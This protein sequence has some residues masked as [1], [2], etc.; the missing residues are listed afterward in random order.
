MAESS[1]GAGLDPERQRLGELLGFDV[2][3]D[4]VDPSA[5]ARAVKTRVADLQRDI[6]V[7]IGERYGDVS[8]TL[9][10]ALQLHKSIAQAHCLVQ[11]AVVES[12]DPD[13]VLFSEE[14]ER[15]NKQLVGEIQASALEIAVLRSLASLHESFIAFDKALCDGNVQRAANL[16]IEVEHNFHFV[17]MATSSSKEWESAIPTDSKTFILIREQYLKKRDALENR[18]REMFDGAIS[19]TQKDGAWNLVVDVTGGNSE[20]LPAVVSVFHML[21]MLPDALVSFS[22]DVLSF[23]FQPFLSEKNASIEVVKTGEEAKISII[24]ETTGSDTYLKPNELF[25]RALSVI[26]FLDDVVFGKLEGTQEDATSAVSS[27]LWGHDM[28]GLCALLIERLDAALPSE[29][30]TETKTIEDM[31]VATKAFEESLRHMRWLTPSTDSALAQYVSNLGTRVAKKRQQHVLASARSI[32]LADYHNSVVVDD[33]MDP[34][35]SICVDSRKDGE[36]LPGLTYDKREEFGGAAFSIERMAVTSCTQRIVALVHTTLRDL[37]HGS[38]EFNRIIWCAVRDV[39]LMF[40]AVVPFIHRNHIATMSRLAMLHYNDCNYICHHLMAFGVMYAHLLPP[41]L[42]ENTRMLDLVPTFRDMGVAT[43]V[44]QLQYQHAE[45]EMLLDRED[46]GGVDPQLLTRR[47][48]M[49]LTRTFNVWAEVLGVVTFEQA[50]GLMVA[51]IPPRIFS[52]VLG[53]IESDKAKIL[54]RCRGACG[55]E[56]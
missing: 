44:K 12:K 40:Q 32:I 20:A 25:A 5:T 54:E 36:S 38:E 35:L 56:G 6:N 31:V 42:R 26:E 30:M 24:L 53:T 39:F 13:S 37:E 29:V 45:I 34:A 18:L 9:S 22:S 8:N 33:G 48:A 55:D 50:M 14:E 47:V 27:N 23:L 7:T 10:S 28:D 4:N 52:D 17:D 49:H 51:K 16:L 21:D 11:S 41:D 19:F 15:S 1:A 3:E 2:G 46:E 43:F